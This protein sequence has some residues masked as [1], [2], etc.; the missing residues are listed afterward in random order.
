MKNSIVCLDTQI[1]IWGVKKQSTP[2]QSEMILRAEYLLEKLQSNGTKILVPSIVVAE[3]LSG[4]DERKHNQFTQNMNKFFIVPPFDTQAAQ[5][6]AKMWMTNK[7][8]RNTLSAEGIT[9]SEMKADCLIVATAIARGCSCIYS[10]DDQLE[11]FAR[12]HIDVKELPIIP[13]KQVEL[14]K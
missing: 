3:I 1:I 6:F 2:D 9:R 14:F 11:K 13:A 10:H 4:I 8:L 7:S 12:G 5:H